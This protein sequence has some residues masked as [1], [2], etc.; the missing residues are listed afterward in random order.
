MPHAD[1]LELE[2][3][4]PEA[5]PVINRSSQWRGVQVEFSRLRLPA[6]YEFNW[7]GSTH[8]LALHDLVLADGEMFVD[9]VPPTP[10]GDLRNKMTFVP[11]ACG[12]RGWAKPV[13]RQ[14]TFTVV[15][16]DPAVLEQELQIEGAASTLQPHIYFNEPDLLS[17]MKKLEGA[18]SGADFSTSTL[19]AETLGLVAA[20]EMFRFQ[21]A[22]EKQQPR[23]GTLT[24]AQQRIVQDF[25]E[26]NLS[27]DFGLDDLASVVGLSRYHFSRCFKAT[28][29][30]PPH[31]FVTGRKIDKAREMLSQPNVSIAETASGTGFN[32]VANFSRTF[33]ELQGM[34]PSDFR[35]VV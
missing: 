22:L 5:E 14:N 3:R 10:G 9:D 34:S 29:G 15:Y 33:R 25:I 8:Y 21:S 19:Y 30:M 7:N 24:A 26:D 6:E 17:T 23:P 2:F 27:A 31:R 28:F 4:Q 18:M 20:L 1:S 11:A 35:R 16:F 32:S 12:L 13:P